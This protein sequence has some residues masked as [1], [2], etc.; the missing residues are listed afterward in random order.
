MSREKKVSTTENT[1][2][3]MKL[4]SRINDL[5][6]LAKTFSVLCDHILDIDEDLGAIFMSPIDELMHIQT[7]LRKAFDTYHDEKSAEKERGNQ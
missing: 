7:D 4:D 3:W 1:V 5:E 6:Y 2:P